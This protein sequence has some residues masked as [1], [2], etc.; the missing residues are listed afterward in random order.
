MRRLADPFVASVVA[1]TALAAA[2]LVVVL[3]AWRGV[4][5]V[6]TVSDQVPFL[7]SGAI[8]GLAM[9]GFAAGVL[10][11]QHRRYLEAQRRADFEAVIHEAVALL[12]A[13]PG[14][15]TGQQR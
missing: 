9:I 2:G 8:A 6:A 10:M 13:R 7:V 14:D 1:L 5:N 11:I 3:L 4:A 12:A 15:D